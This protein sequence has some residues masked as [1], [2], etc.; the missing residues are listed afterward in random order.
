MASKKQKIVQGYAD[1]TKN[2]YSKIFLIQQVQTILMT[3]KVPRSGTYTPLEN[4]EKQ[5][6]Q[7]LINIKEKSLVR[8]IYISICTLTIMKH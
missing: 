8:E 2:S 4:S 1:A 3:G 7:R 5:L 6:T